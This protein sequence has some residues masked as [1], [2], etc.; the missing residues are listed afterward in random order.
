MLCSWP[1]PNH[2]RQKQNRRSC[3]AQCNTWGLFITTFTASGSSLAED[4]LSGNILIFFQQRL[5]Y[6]WPQL[7]YLLWILKGPAKAFLVMRADFCACWRARLRISGCLFISGRICKLYVSGLF[8]F[9]KKKTQKKQKTAWIGQ[10]ITLT[11]S[12]LVLN[13]K[14]GLCCLYSHFHTKQFWPVIVLHDWQAQ[15]RINPMRDSGWA[16]QT[17]VLWSLLH[18]WGS[19]FL[20]G[21]T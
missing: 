8:S 21:V 9:F 3:K 5:S 10:C 19:R 1:A 20:D 17:G 12:D 15:I 11:G 6:V 16:L 13:A 18:A 4:S 7:F 2:G 14:N